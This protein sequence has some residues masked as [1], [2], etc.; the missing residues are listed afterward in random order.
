M[1]RVL[2]SIVL[3]VIVGYGFVEGWPLLSG[4]R[5]VILSPQ[6]G[7]AVAS[8]ILTIAGKAGNAMALTVDG[9]TV[10]PDTNGSFSETLA[11]PQGSSIL[12]FTATDRFGRVVRET[13]QIFVPPTN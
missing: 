9:A 5:L 13:R 8:G 1:T 7:A 10:I 6:N 3:V 12:T 11:F 2:L 4:P